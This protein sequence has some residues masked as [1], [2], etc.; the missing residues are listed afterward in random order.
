MG[1]HCVVNSYMVENTG[2]EPLCRVENSNKRMAQAIDSLFET[3]F[4]A[5]D[6][7]KR[8]EVLHAKFCNTVNAQKL[9]Q[10]IF[11]GE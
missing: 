11:E 4:D 7:S 3:V 5:K 10:L 6:V 1:G 2:L 9:V 8:E